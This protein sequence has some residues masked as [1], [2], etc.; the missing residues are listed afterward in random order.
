MAE[1]SRTGAAIHCYFNGLYS[2][3]GVVPVNGR[4]GNSGFM[5]QWIIGRERRAPFV[6]T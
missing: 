3:T 4:G 2:G 1:S 5:G 6:Y